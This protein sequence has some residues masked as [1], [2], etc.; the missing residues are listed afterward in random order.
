MPGSKRG[1]LDR[2]KP[3]ISSEEDIA[4]GAFIAAIYRALK[5]NDPAINVLRGQLYDAYQQAQREMEALKSFGDNPIIN[6]IMEIDALN[7][8]DIQPLDTWE[9]VR[10]WLLEKVGTTND[11]DDNQGQD[12]IPAD[13]GQHRSRPTGRLME[14]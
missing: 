12:T 6:A 4:E 2:P 9:K 5:Q 1:W 10:E 8:E 13:D 3:G 11:T 7:S 14:D